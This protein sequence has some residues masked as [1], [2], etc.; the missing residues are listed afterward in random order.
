MAAGFSVAIHVFIFMF[1]INYYHAFR[2]VPIAALT[3]QFSRSSETG[4]RNRSEYVVD[5]SNIKIHSYSEIEKS[6]L[7]QEKPTVS[8]QEVQNKSIISQEFRT[9][10]YKSQKEVGEPA[11][12]LHIDMWQPDEPI[13]NNDGVIILK[14]YVGENGNADF[15][16]Y[17]ENNMPDSFSENVVNSF[18]NANY[19][20]GYFDGRPVKSWLKVEIRYDSLQKSENNK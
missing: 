7:N 5:K 3:V 19:T 6:D 17:E 4:T 2:Q 20:P 18:L 11:H 14:I 13:K 8:Q 10:L 12:V 16:E 15:I 1:P 9:E